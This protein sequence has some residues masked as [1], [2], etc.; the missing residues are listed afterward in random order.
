[1]S[2]ACRPLQAT[3]GFF[4]ACQKLEWKDLIE[5]RRYYYVV[6]VIRGSLILI[7][8]LQFHGVWV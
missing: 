6:G 4:W 5:V 3:L 8:H 7:E 2:G 1:M